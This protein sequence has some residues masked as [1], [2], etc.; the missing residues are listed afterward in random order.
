[1]RLTTPAAV[2]SAMF[3]AAGGIIHLREWFEVYRHVPA[4]TPGAAVVRVGFPVNAAASILLVIALVLVV[5]R[6]SRLTHATIVIALAFQ[7][8]SL[9]T[10]FATRMG[11]VFGWSEPTWTPGAEQ[12]RAVEAAAIVAL[13]A[14]AAVARRDRSSGHSQLGH[15]EDVMRRRDED[16]R[17]APAVAPTPG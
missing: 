10:L 9:A 8:A 16:P 2:L 12:T 15:L 6:A 14:L 1:M 13:L 11:S 17:H 3:I 5:R 4:S 7:V